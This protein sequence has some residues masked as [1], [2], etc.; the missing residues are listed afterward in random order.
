MQRL[1]S[2]SKIS[3]YL[4]K[5][6]HLRSKQPHAGSSFE[7]RP[8]EELSRRQLRVSELLKETLETIFS[9]QDFDNEIIKSANVSVEFVTITKDMKRAT[10]YWTVYNERLRKAV[11]KEFQKEVMTTILIITKNRLL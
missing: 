7:K 8:R 4:L 5:D 9:K 11:D 10:V 3:I 2:I 6:I 1:R